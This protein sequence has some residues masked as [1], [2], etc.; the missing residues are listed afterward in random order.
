MMYTLY[1]M[2][3]TQI[4]ISEEQKQALDDVARTTGTS[5]SQLIR[6]AID[7]YVSQARGHERLKLLREARGSW[8]DRKDLPDFAALRREWDRQD[9]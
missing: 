6:D 9:P 2:H 3:R 8:A 1:I 5:L 7:K 4:Y